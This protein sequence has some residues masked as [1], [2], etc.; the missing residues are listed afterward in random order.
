MTRQWAVLSLILAVVTVFVVPGFTKD[1]VVES[2]WASAPI[3]I[4]GLKQDWQ[5][6]TFLTDGGSKAQYALRN[7]GEN[8]YVIF[9]FKDRMSPST[10]EFTGLKVFFNGEG[11]K[12]EDLGVHF[13]K[14]RVTADALIAYKEQ[15]GE[16]LT[17]AGKT[18]IRK[19]SMYTLFEADIINEKKA[20]APADPAVQTDPPIFITGFQDKVLIYELRIP[21]SRTNQPGGIGAEP[22]K[23]IKLGFEWGGM[24]AQ[25]MRDMMAGKVAEGGKADHDLGID[26]GMGAEIDTTGALQ[27]GGEYRRDPR[28][29]MHSFWIDVK[30]AAQRS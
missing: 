9:L 2:K 29:R 8:L 27:S 13:K 30:L 25:I 12:S 20:T 7:D 5:D 26:E 1:T 6:S 23:T 11:K 19:E 15:K 17:D 14:K 18:E 24:T 16:A 3:K 28:T 22:G 10:I 21:L 4:E